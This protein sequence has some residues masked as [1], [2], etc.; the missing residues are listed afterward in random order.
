VE[1]AGLNGT[2]WGPLD[3]GAATLR[4][5][6]VIAGST[7]TLFSV[8]QGNARI[9]ADRVSI[10]GERLS[11]EFDAVR[12]RFEG[13]RQGDRI[14]GT[15]TQ[16]RALP[17]TL[18]R[19]DVPEEP[20]PATRPLEQSFL[21]QMRVAAGTP[22]M[23]AA[24]RRGSGSA[25]TVLSGVGRSGANQ[26]VTEATLWH[27]GSITKS[28]TAVLVARLAEAGVVSWD[29][30]VE[31]VLSPVVGEIQATYREATFRHLLSHKAG[32]QPNLPLELVLTFKDRLGSDVRA[33]RLGYA[34]LALAQTPSG[35]MAG[36]MTYSNN[37]YVVAGAM[38]EQKT[39]KSWEQLIGDHVFKPLGLSSAGFGVP[40]GTG[41]ATGHAAQGR[42]RMPVADPVQGDNPVAL[43]PA[44]RVHM[45]LGDMLTYLS[46]HRD[47]PQNFLPK[48]AWD[49]LHTPP[50]GGTY[51]M[52][53]VAR[54][55]G[56]LWHNGSNTLWYA[57][58]MIDQATGTVAAVTANDAT[59]LTMRALGVV[60]A[61][62]RLA[63]R[64]A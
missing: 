64:E 56:T 30:T 62:A 7:V 28:M 29:D 36:T 31:S 26:P 12:A 6:L 5:K 57:E 19:G 53:L 42:D 51:A 1:E 49:V 41:V 39:G 24:W 3:L 14:V 34:G 16:G 38:M 33:D 37:G 4:L 50:F 32:M 17:L 22:A 10:D 61:S 52:G 35:P 47:R 20:L 18:M 63:A 58:A 59:P 45:S 23:G 11:A 40:V 25:Q 13:T 55:D 15:F 2:W 46:T 43:G 54:S 48:V 27:W 8:D 60:L 9:P 21:D 44:G